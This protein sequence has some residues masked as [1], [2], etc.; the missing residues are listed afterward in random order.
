MIG[1][2]PIAAHVASLKL[3][4]PRTFWRLTG[5]LF[6]V[7]LSTGFWSPL[8][9]V[10]IKTLGAGT[11]DIG[12]VFG[13]YQTTSLLSQYW[14]GRR[15]DR[16]GRRK[17]LLLFGTGALAVAY[18]LISLS[19]QWRWLF[20]VRML[21]GVG[22]AAY[23]TGSL[24]F[25]GDLLE[26]QG[27]RGRLMG[28]YRTFG[29]LAFA[30][31]ALAGGLI[32]DRF[33][34][35]IPFRLAAGCYV[36]AFV[37]AVQ[38]DER[39]RPV[40]AVP[41][42]PVRHT[43]GTHTYTWRALWPFLGLAFTWTFAMGAV[44]SL[45]PVYMQG[46]GYSK[47]AVGGLWGLAALGEVP[48]FI[49]AGYLTDRWGPRRVLI[50]G[51]LCMAGVFFGY[52]LVRILAGF[53][54]VQMVRSFAYACFEAPA[55]VYT[56]ELGLRRQRGRL[57]SFYYSAGGLGGITGSIAGGAVAQRIG[58]PAMFRVVVGLMLLGAFAGGR[59]MSQSSVRPAAESSSD[60]REPVAAE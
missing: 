40:P 46:I 25:V 60:R 39:V 45:W 23:S 1:R 41:A 19:Q 11:R 44:V 30:I 54:L 42:S 22:L 24:A 18:L 6:L 21:E 13:T 2:L 38:L 14:W 59:L 53:V 56:T 27:G 34:V 36:C 33:G 5:I 48:C 35:R 47:T 55:L 50:T 3:K 43:E 37:L 20:A 15:S 32:A 31:A 8:L 7:Y 52:T 12:L 29:S 16:L 4:E 26:D 17:P 49:L 58:L 28:L 10:Y 57:A 51:I 9:P